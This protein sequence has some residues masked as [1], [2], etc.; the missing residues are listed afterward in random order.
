MMNYNIRYINH[1][2]ILANLPQKTGARDF[3]MEAR[4]LKCIEG[5]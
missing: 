3:C 5:L 2:L 1:N 4:D